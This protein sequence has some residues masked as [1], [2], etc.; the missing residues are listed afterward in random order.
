MPKNI[1]SGLPS[2]ISFLVAYLRWQARAA[3]LDMTF[4]LLFRRCCLL[5][6][7]CCLFRRV[8][9]RERRARMGN[10]HS[11]SVS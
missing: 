3:Q 11:I 4:Q 10:V 5:P 1:M 2:F 9:R 6:V 8:L 7:P